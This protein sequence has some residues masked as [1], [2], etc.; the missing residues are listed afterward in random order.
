MIAVFPLISLATFQFTL[1]EAG[2]SAVAAFVF[3]LLIVGLS[4][5]AF[6]AYRTRWRGG[7]IR[8]NRMNCVIYPRLR[9]GF[10]PWIFVS[11]RSSIDGTKKKIIMPWWELSIETDGERGSVHED[12]RFICQFGWLTSR[13]RRRVWWAFGPLLFFEILRG[14]IH[15][16]GSE[17]SKAQVYGLLIIEIIY[18]IVLAYMMPFESTRFVVAPIL[19][20]SFFVSLSC[21]TCLG[22]AHASVN[23]PF[24]D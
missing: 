14:I 12:L 4:T 21:F 10:I 11:R 13:F 1:H 15:G 2:P 19:M 7:R 18:F 22:L 23:T 20:H 24:T 5:A 9:V 3:I 17:N 8:V 16:G 6:A